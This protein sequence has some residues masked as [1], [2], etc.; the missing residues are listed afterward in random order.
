LLSPP[1]HAISRGAAVMVMEILILMGEVGALSAGSAASGWSASAV[2]RNELW[3]VGRPSS[4]NCRNYF[5]RRAV[6]PV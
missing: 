2:R 5:E 6:H 3:P 4:G 1:L